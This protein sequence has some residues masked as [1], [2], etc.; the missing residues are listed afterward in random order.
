[1]HTVSVPNGAEEGEEFH[2]EVVAAPAVAGPK[3]K[4]HSIL[5]FAAGVPAVAPASP[6][7]LKSFPPTAKPPTPGTEGRPTSPPVLDKQQVPWRRRASR[8]CGRVVQWRPRQVWL[9]DQGRPLEMG[10]HPQPGEERAA[11][12]KNDIAFLKD[13][14]SLQLFTKC[15]C[16]PQHGQARPKHPF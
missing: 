5:R 6:S 15:L 1:M 2:T 16:R 14:V 9:R 3:A 12:R 7:K 8:E 4:A 10:I 11:Q 13:I